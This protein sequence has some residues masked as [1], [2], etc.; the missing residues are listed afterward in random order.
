MQ[1]YILLAVACVV[2]ASCGGNSSTGPSPVPPPVVIPPITLTGHVT[3]TNGGQ[4]LAGLA[5]DLGGQVA[6]TD[7]AGGFA[8]QLAPGAPGRLLLSGAGIVPRSLL[9]A[10]GATREVSVEMF[11]PGFDLDYFRKIARDG[12]DSPTNLQP[13]RRLVQAPTVYLR[14]V[15]EAGAAIDA[16]TLNAT[17]AALMSVGGSLTVTGVERGTETR[18]GVAGWLTVKWPSPRLAGLCGRSSVGRDGGAIELNYLSPTCGC[19]ASRIR[20]THV[21]HE[22]GH[23]FGLYH[24]DTAS[25]LMTGSAVSECDRRLTAREQQYAGFLYARPVGNTDPDVDPAGA[26]TLAPMS[27]R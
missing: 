9:V 27:A 18:E 23:A 15:D 1:N 6:T 8:V 21:R 11:G 22:L 13:L 10:V 7:G 2:C 16:A 5:V 4:P 17:A 25:D 3:A 19:G 12:V 14:T 26:V 24:T 20:P